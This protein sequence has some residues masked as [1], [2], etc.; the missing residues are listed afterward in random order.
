MKIGILTFGDGRKRV[1][2]FAT[3][4][5]MRFQKQLQD[6]LESRGHSVVAGNAVVWNHETVIKQCERLNNAGVEAVVF[7]FAIWSYPDLTAQAAIRFDPSISIMM[8]GVLNPS[9]PGWVAYFASAGSMT[10]IGRPF[11][12]A[13]GDLNDPSVSS[14][15]DQW[16]NDGDLKQRK[17]GIAAAKQLHGL[18]YGRFD[19]PSMGMY[20][21]H[22]DES[23][24]MSQFGVHVYH[25][26]Q[27]WLWE[28][29]KQIAAKRVKAGLEW[30]E[31]VCKEVKY[32]GK[33]LTRGPNGTLARQVRM[34]LAM[35]DFCRDEGIDF[36]GL[37]GQLDMTESPD[38][39]IMDVQEALLND[40][41]D[42]ENSRKKPLI[43][44]TECDS[45]GA[46]TMQIM[47]LISGTPVLFA[48]MRHYFADH[49]VYDLVN[50]GEHAPWFSYRDK[51]YK[52]NWS[53]VTL[54]PAVDFYFN[55]GGAS[56]QF[57]SE[58][59]ELITLGR[60]TRNKGRFQMHLVRAS[61]PDL[62]FETMESLAKQTT[63]T[64]P[65]MYVRFKCPPEAIGQ[66]YCSNHIHGIFGD[67]VA[68]ITGACEYLGMEVT[69]LA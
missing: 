21:G 19:G 61:V 40:T 38:M 48:D 25:R 35:K 36:C 11:A 18:R 62:G 57:Y 42:W 14:A 54:Y 22:V 67:H 49:D 31:N 50:S 2:E 20:T 66:H 1:T 9:Y 53:A 39:C 23:Q 52:K 43:C 37:T 24:W 29:S 16:F 58:P 63:Y 45:N 7:N 44:A 10:E 68:A 15:F 26:G 69:V 64:W 55:A 30:L 27:L 56:V 32:D 17:K 13:L 65:H 33:K 41:A 8:Y 28:L 60:I 47:H 4:D 34:Y 3:K 5:C 51:N 12:R 6:F 59:A 46:L